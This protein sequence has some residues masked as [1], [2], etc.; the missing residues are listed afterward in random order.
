M[1]PIEMQNISK[2][3]RGVDA[4]NS[5]N[6]KVGRGTIHALVGENG[7]G[8]STLMKILYGMVQPD[9]GIIRIDEREVHLRNPSDAICRG[10]G[11]VH[12]HFML[13]PTFS[14]T[15]NIVLG[16]EPTGHLGRLELDR[17]KHMISELS[18]KYN[19]IVDPDALVRDLSIGMQQR[20]EILKTLYRS[21]DKIILDEPTAVLIPQEIDDLFEILKK[22]T[23]EG[24]TVIIITHKLNEIMDVSDFVTV[25]RRGKV[26]F[27]T[28]TSQT[29]SSEI[30]RK[31]I[32]RELRSPSPRS[33]FES[34][35]EILVVKNLFLTDRHDSAILKDISF[36]I[37]SGEILGI[38]GVEG[39]GQSQLV[40]VLTGLRKADKGSIIFSSNPAIGG[41]SHQAVSHIPEDRQARGLIL[42]YSIEENMILGRQREK[43]FNNP[44]SL[45]YAHIRNFAEEIVNLYD[46][47]TSSGIE[48]VRG[49][50]G[51]NQQK[52]VVGRELTKD[53]ELIIASQPTR[54]LDVGATEFV[55][56]SL[57]AKRNE[58]RA[59]LLVSSD[60]TELLTL[61]D[62]IGVMFRGELVEILDAREHTEY[63]LGLYMTGAS[64]KSA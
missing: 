10:I 2:R 49:L 17:A 34:F 9:S 58:G 29:T 53:T 39:N 18:Q 50:S 52:I 41:R 48:N 4:N 23:T 43:A 19:I 7:A 3:F 38:A 14:V 16:H 51:G 61:S 20:V 11:M 15:E 55:H 37:H 64:R 36:S 56:E 40:E 5:V 24:K 13:I 12:Q 42:E 45:D 33:A 46:I 21:T 47:R 57:L 60:L 30:S 25:M 27:E 6:L 26:V 44:L 31:M 63:D 22:L 35:R 8:K 32:G 62:R 28:A 59:I 1:H 54:G